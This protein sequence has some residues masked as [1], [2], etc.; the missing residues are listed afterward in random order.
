MVETGFE[1]KRNAFQARGDRFLE[2]LSKKAKS[3]KFGTIDIESKADDTQRAGFT[4]PFLTGFY[5]P[6]KRHYESFKNEAHLAKRPWKDRHV[7]PGG[8]I[9]KLLSVILTKKYSKYTFY[10][11]NGGKFDFLFL[12]R[13]LREHSDE[14]EHEIVPIQS[15]IQ[16]VRVWERS[17]DPDNPSKVSW[18]FHDS[19]KL[20]PMSLAKACETFK[21]PAG[22]LQHD[23][24]LHEDSPLWE[25]YLK[26]D[27]IALATVVAMAEEL[28]RELGGAMAMTTPAASMKLFRMKYLGEDGVPDKISRFRHWDDCASPATCGGCAHEWIRKSYYGGRTEMHGTGQEMWTPEELGWE[29]LPVNED[30]PTEKQVREGK[31]FLRNED[32]VWQGKTVHYYDINSSYVATMRELM[33]TGT[34]LVEHPATPADIDWQK[35]D[36]GEWGGFVECRV[37]IPASCPIPPLPYPDRDTGKLLFPAG[38]FNGVWTTAELSLLKDPIVGGRIV[39][40]KRVVWFRMQPMFNRMM[41]DLWE[42]RNKERPDYS[43]GKSALGKLLGNSLYGK[44]G[45]KHERE[46]IVYERQERSLSP[47]GLTTCILCKGEVP[48]GT[49]VLFCTACEGSKNA[50]PDCEGDVWYQRKHV[51]APYIIPS[52]AS[53]ITARSRVRLWERMKEVVERGG[54]LYYCDTDSIITD[55]VLESSNKLGA[56]KDEFPGD[57]LRYLG[58]GNKAY[59]VERVG[60]NDEAERLRAVLDGE[61][62]STLDGETPFGLRAPFNRVA[63]KVVLKGFSRETKTAENFQKLRHG[64]TLGWQRLEQVRTLARGGF[65]ESPQMADVTKSIKSRYDKRELLPDGS[66]CSRVVFEAEW[67]DSEERMAAE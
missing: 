61:D 33:P 58:I 26:Q 4:R 27:C 60:T 7:A 23:L 16:V 8:C 64:A 47:N 18:E 25:P 57:R 32:G 59:M 56:M 38:T 15:S 44:F 13:W 1:K 52:I 36:S 50:D 46:S 42:L 29:G 51:D 5:D 40:V 63:P 49:E 22:K 3:K 67:A 62:P 48:E 45:M 2:P 39:S 53:W 20:L 9:D 28:I 66:T 10:A 12:L 43:D 6:H 41:H 24:H 31:Q 17:E 37:E 34:R 19:L 30:V 21:L 65:R 54:R 55:V 14:Y 35:H 11:H